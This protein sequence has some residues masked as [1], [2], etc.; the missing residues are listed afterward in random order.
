MGAD[1]R[2]GAYESE[3]PRSECMI[4]CVDRLGRN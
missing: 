4:R 3:G 2:Q 1:L